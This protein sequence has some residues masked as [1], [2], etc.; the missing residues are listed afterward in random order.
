M[1]EK[2]KLAIK[3]W[4]NGCGFVLEY[5]VVFV[6]R[7]KCWVLNNSNNKSNNSSNNN[8]HNSDNNSHNNNLTFMIL[9]L[10]NSYN[11]FTFS[12]YALLLSPY[13]IQSI[14]SFPTNSK[15]SPYL[16][17]HLSNHPYH[18]HASCQPYF[19]HKFS[20]S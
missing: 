10:F 4:E 7:L 15:Y 6:D 9:C 8:N 17:L 11:N 2:K 5:V 20:A 13:F 3:S 12:Y 16:S 18:P 19:N 1:S 14:N